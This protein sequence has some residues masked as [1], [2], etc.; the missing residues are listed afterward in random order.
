MPTY[1]YRYGAVVDV[2]ALVS[3][4]SGDRLYRRHEPGPAEASDDLRP[5]GLAVERRFV[6]RLAGWLRFTLT[7]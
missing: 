5:E 2:S 3:A 6:R 4:L 1:Q 7:G